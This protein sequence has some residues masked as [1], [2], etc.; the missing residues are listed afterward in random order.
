MPP[1]RLGGASGE[2]RKEKAVAFDSDD[3]RLG[4]LALSELNVI[5][6]RHQD[7]TGDLM[8]DHYRSALNRRIVHEWTIG[9]DVRGVCKGRAKDIGIEDLQSTTREC[10]RRLTRSG[11][12]EGVV[13]AGA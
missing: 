11:C 13:R 4:V 2:I 8:P 5:L 10:T 9:S 3:K 6:C 12:Q 1:T 7:C